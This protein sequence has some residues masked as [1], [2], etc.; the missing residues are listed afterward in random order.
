MLDVL[1]F[2]E[3][4]CRGRGGEERDHPKPLL[5]GQLFENVC[6][7][8]RMDVLDE[9]AE[10]VGVAPFE[11]LLQADCL[12]LEFGVL[13]QGA[14]TAFCGEPGVTEC[15][16]AEGASRN[17]SRQAANQLLLQSKHRRGVTVFPFRVVM[18]QHV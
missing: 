9:L 10:R 6:Q 8:A 18:S 11:Q 13:A 3:D 14:S 5:L 1:H 4:L 12:F 16:P 17:A 2:G 15:R 7:V